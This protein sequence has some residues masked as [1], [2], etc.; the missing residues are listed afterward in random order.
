MIIYSIIF[1]NT[2]MV[3]DMWRTN[4]IIMVLT[5]KECSLLFNG[6]MSMIVRKSMPKKLPSPFKVYVY[7]K[8]HKVG[9]A[10]VNEVLNGVYGGGKVV[11]E[12]VCDENECFTVGS[13]RCDEIEELACLSYQKMIEY[14]YKPEELDGKT[15]KAGTALHIAKP[16]RYDKPK[17]LSEFTRYGYKKIEHKGSGDVFCDNTQCRYCEPDEV[18]AGLYRPP[19]CRKG[20]CKITRPPQ[21]FCYVEEIEE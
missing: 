3:I 2:D 21:S 15:V 7:Q 20:G 8:K 16:K 18:I 5:P 11:G 14:F 6:N 1:L 12:F 10:I 13:L 19:V 17:E 4:A 9:K